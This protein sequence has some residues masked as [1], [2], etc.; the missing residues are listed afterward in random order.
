[1]FEEQAAGDGITTVG[2]G[3]PP[4]SDKHFAFT[5]Y[6]FGIT[7]IHRD[8]RIQSCAGIYRRNSTAKWCMDYNTE[9]E[10]GSKS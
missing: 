1:M 9:Q 10:G 3:A 2:F 4:I 6:K 7:S 5:I 8:K